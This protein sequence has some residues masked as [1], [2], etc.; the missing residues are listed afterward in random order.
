LIIDFSWQD[1]LGIWAVKAT[2]LVL[3]QF[4]FIWLPLIAAIFLPWPAR[5]ADGNMKDILGDVEKAL[6]KPTPTPEPP[7][8]PISVAPFQ[9]TTSGEGLSRTTQVPVKKQEV[10]PQKAAKQ[11]K[12][13]TTERSTI[14]RFS[15][16]S[17]L[18]S[19]SQLKKLPANPI[20]TWLYGDFVAARTDG[21][22]LLIHPIFAGG[23]IRGYSTEVHVTFAGGVPQAVV[24][25]LPQDPMYSTVGSS[26][27]K[28]RPIH[29]KA[30]N[31]TNNGKLQVI[32]TWY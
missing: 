6:E 30:V 31:R 10:P 24:Q 17:N 5:S 26:F 27:P 8:K 2:R 11:Q 21:R 13:P 20:D 23:F 15:T 18:V 7:P 22:I 1:K 12:P 19:A 32:G 14:P 4:R 28:N 16:K 9:G 3:P 29:I 25:Q